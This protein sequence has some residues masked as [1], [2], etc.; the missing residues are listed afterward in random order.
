MFSYI[1]GNLIW[2]C[3]IGLLLRGVWMDTGI[4]AFLSFY[5]TSSCISRKKIKLFP[6][7]IFSFLTVTLVTY[8]E[9]KLDYFFHERY[10]GTIHYYTIFLIY[11]FRELMVII[12]LF[13]KSLLVICVSISSLWLYTYI[14]NICS[15]CC[16]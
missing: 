1:V 10:S 6:A 11:S 5:L 3:G 2:A 7:N 4:R 16:K 14:Y 9:N 12:R 13:L 15:K 8:R